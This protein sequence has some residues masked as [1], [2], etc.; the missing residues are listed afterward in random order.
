MQKAQNKGE[1]KTDLSTEP[2]LKLLHFIQNGLF[3]HFATIIVQK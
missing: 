1:I 2:W 3:G